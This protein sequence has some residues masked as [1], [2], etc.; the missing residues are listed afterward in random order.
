MAYRLGVLR[1]EDPEAGELRVTGDGYA[2]AGEVVTLVVSPDVQRLLRMSDDE[3]AAAAEIDR[4]YR[5]ALRAVYSGGGWRPPHLDP[6][7]RPA[8]HEAER[9]VGRLL[10]EERMQLV[11][12]LSWRARG[13]DALLDEDVADVLGLTEEQRRRAA[14]VAEENEREIARTTAEI[15]AVRN[16]GAGRTSDSAGLG[17]RVAAADRAGRARLLAVLTPQQR[18]R[19]TRLATS[20]E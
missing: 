6:A 19:F 2:A 14:T 8:R 10:G 17:E 1:L 4:Q 11:R 18:E 9:Q 13:A 3:V 5:K 16:R 20:A 12:R 7:A 15:S